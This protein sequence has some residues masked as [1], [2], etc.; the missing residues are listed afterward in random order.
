MFSFSLADVALSERSCRNLPGKSKFK[1]TPD[2]VVLKFAASEI[3]L[4]SSL[5]RSIFFPFFFFSQFSVCFKMKMVFAKNKTKRH[6]A[7][8]N[9]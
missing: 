9:F 8:V 5:K 6:L 1:M 3:Y 4:D 7:D 2:D